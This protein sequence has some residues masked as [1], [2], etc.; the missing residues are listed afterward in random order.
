MREDTVTTKVYLFDELSDE[1]KQRAIEQ[2]W[3][4]N[5]DYEWW[6]CVYEDAATIGLKITEFDLDRG[7]Y[8][9]GDW[10]ED[11]EDTAR[12]ILEN[13]GPAD[14]SEPDQ[15]ACETYKDAWEFQ[16][17]VSVQGSIFED[18]D[19][20]D[21][22]YQEFTESD[23]YLELCEEFQR[24]ICEDYRIILQQEYEY[25]ISEEAIIEVIKANEYEFTEDGKLY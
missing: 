1:A 12:L 23:E 8:C 10:T 19:D 15:D 5:V 21:P 4:I 14:G 17:A 18:R 3:D 6:D 20:Y 16:N 2:L 9:R 22:E 7:A 24:T 13:H 25:R 11:P